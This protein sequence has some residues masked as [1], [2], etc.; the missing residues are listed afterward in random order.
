[1]LF[2]FLKK[3]IY[4]SGDKIC[5]EQHGVHHNGQLHILFTTIKCLLS[6]CIL[7]QIQKILFLSHNS[8]LGQSENSNEQISQSVS[9]KCITSAGHHVMS[10]VSYAPHDNLKKGNNYKSIIW[11]SVYY[12]ISPLDQIIHDT[13]LCTWSQDIFTRHGFSRTENGKKSFTSNTPTTQMIQWNRSIEVLITA[14]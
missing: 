6:T 4:C 8:V 11:Q 10:A 2:S 12:H 14:L 5:T 7:S 9:Y 13:G 3:G 1:L